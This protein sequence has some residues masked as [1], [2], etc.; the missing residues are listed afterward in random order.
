MFVSSE[1]AIAVRHGSMDGGDYHLTT[2]AAAR[3]N[4]I[5]TVTSLLRAIPKC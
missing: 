2:R 1:F 4:G 5:P 3:C